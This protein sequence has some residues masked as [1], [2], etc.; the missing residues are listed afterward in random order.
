MDEETPWV[1]CKVQRGSDLSF[2]RYRLV[3]LNGSYWAYAEGSD[4]S[5]APETAGAYPLDPSGLREL[6]EPSLSLK[7]YEYRPVLVS[8]D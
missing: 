7:V 5:L 2:D 8:H 1:T 4:L 6:P 3:K